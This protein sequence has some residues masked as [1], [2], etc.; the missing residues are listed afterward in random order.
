MLDLSR[1]KTTEYKIKSVLDLV[2]GPMTVMTTRKCWDPFII[3]KVRDMIK[4]LARSVP[5]EE[6]LKLSLIR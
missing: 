1:S 4:Q 5:Y 3:I 2:E 6:A